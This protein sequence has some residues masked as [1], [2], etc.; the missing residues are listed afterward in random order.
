M[1]EFFDLVEKRLTTLSNDFEELK[2]AFSEFRKAKKI[3]D[4]KMASENPFMTF[5]QLKKDMSKTNDELVQNFYNEFLETLRTFINGYDSIESEEYLKVKN[6]ASKFFVDSDTM[7]KYFSEFVNDT[8]LEMFV[9]ELRVVLSENGCHVEEMPVKKEGVKDTK[10][11]KYFVENLIDTTRA[12]SRKRYKAFE[13]Q[14]IV[15]KEDKNEDN[16]E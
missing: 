15:G 12:I 9:N 6:F 14:I 2:S 1:D 11:Y 4:E 5:L 13:E 16:S 7:Y 8:R 10:E 3:R